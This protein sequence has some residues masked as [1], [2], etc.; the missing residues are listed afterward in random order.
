M[1][2]LAAL[3]SSAVGSLLRPAIAADTGGVVVD[4][5]RRPI[6]GASVTILATSTTVTTGADG[7]FILRRLPRGTVELSVRAIGFRPLIHL[8][9][10]AR[11]AAGRDTIVLQAAPVIL[12][13]L[14]VEA[15]I[16]KPTFQLRTSVIFHSRAATTPS[17]GGAS[18]ARDGFNTLGLVIYR[19]GRDVLTGLLASSG[20][21]GPPRSGPEAPTPD[22]LD[23]GFDRRSLLGGGGREGCPDVKAPPLATF[24]DSSTRR[25]TVLTTTGEVWAATIPKGY[26]RPCRLTQQI[27]FGGRA[28]AGSGDRDGW[29]VTVR[30]GDSTVVARWRHSAGLAFAVPVDSL[31]AD[32]TESVVVAASEGR[33]VVARQQWPFGWVELTASGDVVR[34]SMPTLAESLLGR[35]ADTT[36]ASWHAYAVLPIEDGFV[37]TVENKARSERKYLLFD[38]IGRLVGFPA[39]SLTPVLVAVVPKSRLVLG[40]HY[41][42]PT[43]TR[44]D[45]WLFAY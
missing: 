14:E 1:L 2:V 8:L 24:A 25:F 34:Q 4:S 12:R 44:A 29:V 22:G 7:R 28:I 43:G 42:N 41:A 18:F 30:R 5:T 38:R 21:L 27:D 40:F 45:P 13:P 17:F 20:A 6:G 36:I 37:Q 26:L 16:E 10:R 39:G 35:L 33:T 15:T 23:A 9:D 11:A 3:L 19:L 31:F 32:R